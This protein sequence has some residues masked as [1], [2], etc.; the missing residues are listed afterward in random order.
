MPIQIYSYQKSN[1]DSLKFS[2]IRRCKNDPLSKH[3]TICV[4][5]ILKDYSAKEKLNQYSQNQASMEHNF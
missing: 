5:D 2:K 4:Q 1:F 3:T